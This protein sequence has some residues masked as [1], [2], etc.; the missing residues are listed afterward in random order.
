[1]DDDL[2]ARLESLRVVAE[3]LEAIETAWLLS[4]QQ[5]SQ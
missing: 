4:P 1:M 2:Q 5:A 3:T